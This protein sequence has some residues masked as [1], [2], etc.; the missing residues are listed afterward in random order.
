[1]NYLTEINSSKTLY[2]QYK[3]KNLN[4]KLNKQKEQSFNQST[5]SISTNFSI[6]NNCVTSLFNQKHSKEKQYETNL[7]IRIL[8]QSEEK[9]ISY[10][11]NK[12]KDNFSSNVTNDNRLIPNIPKSNQIGILIL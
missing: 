11:N 5:R 2:N 10:I 1:M 12:D 6:F 8:K 7:A 9:K 3:S 4:S